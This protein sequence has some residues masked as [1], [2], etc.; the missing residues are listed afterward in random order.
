MLACTLVHIASPFIFAL[1]EIQVTE[2][3][4][5]KIMV[6]GANFLPSHSQDVYDAFFFKVES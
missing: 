6:C 4:P 2:L 1:K 5:Y 3:S